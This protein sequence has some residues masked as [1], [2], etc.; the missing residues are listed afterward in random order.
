MERKGLALVLG[1][2]L[3]TGLALPLPECYLTRVNCPMK[4]NGS[5]HVFAGQREAG[6][7]CC[8]QGFRFSQSRGNHQKP[9]KCY[10]L[11]RKLKTYPVRSLLTV[12][13]D[14]AVAFVI[15]A[16]ASKSSNPTLKNTGSKM[17]ARDRQRAGPIFVQNQSLLI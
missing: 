8:G 13:P 10:E 2:M 9:D 11:F 15:G 7:S 3:L 14:T 16:D 1:M 4:T 17:L 5:C 12:V 6:K